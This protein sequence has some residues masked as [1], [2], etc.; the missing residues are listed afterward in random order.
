MIS[1]HFFVVH[2]YFQEFYKVSQKIFCTFLKVFK[3][4]RLTMKWAIYKRVYIINSIS[5]W[6]ICMQ[7]THFCEYTMLNAKTS[8]STVKWEPVFFLVLKVHNINMPTFHRWIPAILLFN[9][10]R[11]CLLSKFFEDLSNK[12]KLKF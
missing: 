5:Q 6:E 3:V 4:T 1:S 8:I 2:V 9:Y 12:F 10:Y 7:N 11:I